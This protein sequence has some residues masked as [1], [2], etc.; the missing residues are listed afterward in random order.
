MPWLLRT[1]AMTV[2]TRLVRNYL[3]RNDDPTPAAPPPPAANRTLHVPSR[4]LK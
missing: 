1:L 3:T 4:R 2:G